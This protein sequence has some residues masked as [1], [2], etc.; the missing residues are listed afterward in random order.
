MIKIQK[1]EK[2]LEFDCG[3]ILFDYKDLIREYDYEEVKSKKVLFLD[4]FSA[5]TWKAIPKIELFDEEDFSK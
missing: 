3:D 1:Q 2:A 4:Y 5:N